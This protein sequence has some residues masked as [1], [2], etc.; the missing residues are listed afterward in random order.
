[1]FG[2]VCFEKS[3]SE[4]WFFWR[5]A[6]SRNALVEG[7]GRTRYQIPNL[8]LGEKICLTAATRP[9]ISLISSIKI[10]KLYAV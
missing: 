3:T 6:Y 7:K 4:K 2:R 8:N 10:K 5:P 9:D 1:M